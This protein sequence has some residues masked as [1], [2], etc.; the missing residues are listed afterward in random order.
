MGSG[1][2]MKMPDPGPWNRAYATFPK[3]INGTWVW[4]DFYFW[5]E[6]YSPYVPK[7]AHYVD[8]RW[9][10]EYGTIFDVLESD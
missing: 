10:K 6:V 5:R 8:Y 9:A 3:K 4:R 1:V 2:S 7:G